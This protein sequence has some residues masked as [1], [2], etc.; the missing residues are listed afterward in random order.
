MLSEFVEGLECLGFKVCGF[1]GVRMI[2]DV[3]YK[4]S[5]EDGQEGFFQL[6]KFFLVDGLGLGFELGGKVGFFNYWF[7]VM[8]VGDSVD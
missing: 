1:F 7:V 2:I 3:L 6:K 5:F 8:D 4:V